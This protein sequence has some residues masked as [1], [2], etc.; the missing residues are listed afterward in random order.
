MNQVTAAESQDSSLILIV[1][2]IIQNLQVLGNI[3]KSF[4]YRVA[5]A[6]D[7]NKALEVTNMIHPDLI[8]L[9]VTMPNLNGFEVCQRI[10]NSEETKEIPIIFLTARVETEDIVKGFEVGGV[11]YVTKPFNS[12]ELLQRVHT[13]LELKRSRDIQKALTVMLQEKTDALMHTNEQLQITNHQL[14]ERQNI[15]VKLIRDISRMKLSGARHAIRNFGQRMFENEKNLIM[16]AITRQ[17]CMAFASTQ[18]TSEVRVH[19]LEACRPFGI[20]APM[21]SDT[22]GVETSLR[23][24][25]I[26]QKA[27]EPSTPPA[28]TLAVTGG[29]GDLFA[30]DIVLDQ[31]YQE[32]TDLKR[33]YAAS[34]ADTHLGLFDPFILFY[35]LRDI[36]DII[37]E[38]N[39]RFG[40]VGDMEVLES[41]ALSTALDEAKKQALAEKNAPLSV[42]CD[43]K[44]DPLFHTNKISLVYMLR[45]ILYNAIDAAARTVTVSSRCPSQEDALRHQDVCRFEDYPMLY[46]CI[47][48]DGRGLAADKA[49]ELN[50]YLH[51]KTDDA[52]ALS[53]KENGGLGTKNLRDFLF[54]HKG[55][56]YYELLQST[57]RIHLYFEQLEA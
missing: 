26:A 17:I 20:T 51:G 21:M 30:D 29:L 2:D 19:L 49:A 5:L 23:K 50:A 54:L 48:D 3:L 14:R 32:F 56:C 53:T 33:K 44:F 31:A 9:D 6:T 25:L 36:A 45:D 57:T 38:I 27:S 55:Q 46:V 40:D 4:G 10:K 24:V 7:G 47:A 42:V 22:A 8:L 13:H 41:V 11:D 1:D 28:D 34:F 35:C 43:F 18:E 37:T 52:H 15:I 39:R 16:Q 12:A